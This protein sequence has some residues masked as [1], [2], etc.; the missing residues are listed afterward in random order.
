MTKHIGQLYFDDALVK[1]VEANSPYTLNTV[2]YTSPEQDGWM[3][4]EATDDY[5]PFVE[6]VQLTEDIADGLLAWITIAVN[7]SAN[8]SDQYEPAAHYWAGG[9]VAIEDAGEGTGP[10]NP[11]VVGGGTT[12]TCT[13]TPTDE[14]LPVKVKY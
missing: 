14:T 7:T 10:S 9:G 3:L 4:E 6:Y 8:H 2:A 12:P 11:C 13:I 1:A 5:D